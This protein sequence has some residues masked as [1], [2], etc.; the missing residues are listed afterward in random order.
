MPQK[1]VKNSLKLSGVQWLA[2]A[3]HMAYRAQARPAVCSGAQSLAAFS[4]RHPRCNIFHVDLFTD[5]MLQDGSQNR[6][7]TVASAVGQAAL[8]ALCLYRGCQDD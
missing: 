5:L 8:G 3:A 1:T 7:I 2:A 4:C 6:D